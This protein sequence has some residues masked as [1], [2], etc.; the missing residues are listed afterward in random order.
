MIRRF[1]I[2]ALVVCCAAM[3]ASA[4]EGEGAPQPGQAVEALPGDGEQQQIELSVSPSGAPA[5]P[6]TPES[7]PLPPGTRDPFWPVAYVPLSERKDD[8]S[9]TT[10]AGPA[11]VVAPRLESPQWDLALKTLIIK[12]VMKSGAGYM[13]VINGQ[14]TSEGDT[15]S[16]VFKSRTYSWRIAKIGKEG[17]RFERL[18]LAQ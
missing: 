14:V 11:A 1:Q 12:G 2:M 13:A 6:A 15:I 4:Q 9:K 18:E 10:T 7:T 8:A 3:S 16:A 5:E 17:V